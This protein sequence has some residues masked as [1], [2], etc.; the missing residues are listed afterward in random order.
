MILS[1]ILSSESGKSCPKMCPMVVHVPRVPE[2]LPRDSEQDAWT[3]DVRLLPETNSGRSEASEVHNLDFA[4]H[5][6]TQN[7]ELTTNPLLTDTSSVV[8]SY[9]KRTPTKLKRVSYR[10]LCA[11]TCTILH[12]PVKIL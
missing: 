9:P 7:L 5:G 1:A 2:S 12:G 10:D 11:K 4:S 6:S 8:K 3:S